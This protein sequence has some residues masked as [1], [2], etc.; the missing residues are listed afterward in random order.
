MPV[1]TNYSLQ[2]LMPA[3]EPQLAATAPVALACGGPVGV[4]GAYAQGQA[5]GLIGGAAANHVF[6]LTIT[7]NGATGFTGYFT[8]Y[9]DRVYV[10]NAVSGGTT[11]NSSAA[12]PTAAQIQAALVA[13]VPGWSGNVT[14]TGTA[15]TAYTITFNNLMAAK[16]VGGLLLFTVVAST[17]GTPTGAVTVGTQ[18]SAGGAQYAPYASGGTPNRVDA[19]LMNYLLIDPVGCPV[20]S[21]ITADPVQ[22]GMG[23]AAY[24]RGYFYV[25]A[26]GYP[27][28]VG[29]D[30]NALTITPYKVVLADVGTSLTDT[31]AMVSLR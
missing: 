17:G 14:V 12:L 15:G 27:G 29:L 3:K 23:F 26:T 11:A 20:T 18:G 30:A 5:L 9:G 19:A 31:G 4:G 13:A 22:A 7:A 28:I 25:D 16:S 1:A 8:Y 21:S 24:T 2:G 10:G 6:T